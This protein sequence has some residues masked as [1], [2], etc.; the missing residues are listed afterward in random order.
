V[1]K[2]RKTDLLVRIEVEAA[3]LASGVVD[4]VDALVELAQ[5]VMRAWCMRE[6]RERERDGTNTAA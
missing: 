3:V 1:A 5:L 2:A 6:K 4:Q